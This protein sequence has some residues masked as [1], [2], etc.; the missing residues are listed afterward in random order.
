[1]ALEG[2][3]A[4]VREFLFLSDFKFTSSNLAVVSFDKNGC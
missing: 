1:M 4:G 3:Q 2:T